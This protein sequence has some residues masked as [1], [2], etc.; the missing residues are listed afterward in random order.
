[1]LVLQIMGAIVLLFLLA[2]IRI[3]RP[4]H[5]ILIERLGEYKRMSVKGFNWIIPLIDRAIYVDITE[6]LNNIDELQVIT[7][8]GLNA[9]VDAQIYEKVKA[10]EVSLKASQYNAQDYKYQIINLARTTLRKVIADLTLKEANSKRDTINKKLLDVLKTEAKSWGLDVLRAEIS[11]IIP[12]ADVQE[13]MNEI[14]KANNKK[15]AAVD[16]ATAVETE[17]SGKAKGVIK[18]AEGDAKSTKLRADA[19]AYAIKTVQ[20][21][22]RKHFRGNAQLFKKLEVTQASLQDNAKWVITEKGVNPTLVFSDKDV[23]PLKG[24]RVEQ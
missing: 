1:M 8:D 12:P 6:S 5:R 24:K 23:I 13:T 10:D 19:K 15:E 3:V 21:S 17:A 9:K 20:E 11:E 2:G 4:T 14:V 22:A 7:K 16:F 18:I